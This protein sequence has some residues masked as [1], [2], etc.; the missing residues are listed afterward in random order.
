MHKQRYLRGNKATY[1]DE[2]HALPSGV[3]FRVDEKFYL[4][5]ENQFF[6]WYFDVYTLI[7]GIFEGL[8]EMITP[9]STVNMIKSGYKASVHSSV[10]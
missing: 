6:L 9:K 3:I 7:K 4:K 10:N 2:V 1:F 8:V 5:Y